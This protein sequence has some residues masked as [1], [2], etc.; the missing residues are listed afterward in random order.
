[1][2]NNAKILLIPQYWTFSLLVALG[3]VFVFLTACSSTPGSKWCIDGDLGRYSLRSISA[4]EKDKPGCRATYSS[5]SGAVA[6]VF[7]RQYKAGMFEDSGVPVEFE[8]QMV[9]VKQD[10]SSKELV[11]S[12]YSDEMAVILTADGLKKPEG[13]V[14]RAYLHR[15]PSRVVDRVAAVEKDVEMLKMSSRQVPS[16]ASIHL[17]LARNYRKLG[18]TIMAVNEYQIAVEK[19]RHC[20][21]CYFEMGTLFR[22]L[23]HWDLS[24]RAL[25]R[26]VAIEPQLAKA[27]LELGD[28]AFYVQNRLEAI[29]G[30]EKALDIGLSGKD[31][32][33]ASSRLEELHNGKFM[34]Q[35]L[36]G[37][38][39]S[40]RQKEK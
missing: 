30:Y 5:R 4:L 8:K 21:P 28:V 17:K 27:W 26:A 11:L 25:R 40:S 23:R 39:A 19:D 14:L 31:R 18:N 37:V 24:I 3:M 22:Q 32:Q 12:W 33:R 1:M 2:N 16:D 29:R 34:I 20:Y 13:P 36:P 15:Y 38:R 35:L 9:F 7:V 6:R 10:T